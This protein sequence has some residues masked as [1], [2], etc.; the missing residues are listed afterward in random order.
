MTTLHSRTLSKVYYGL[1]K[2]RGANS[3]VWYTG[4][5]N[6]GSIVWKERGLRSTRS[7]LASPNARSG[8]TITV[9][10]HLSLPTFPHHGCEADRPPP[11]GIRHAAPRNA[12]ELCSRLKPVL[13]ATLPPSP[14]PL[15][16]RF[17]P[18]AD[19]GEPRIQTEQTH[20]PWTGFAT[21]KGR[22][23][24][25]LFSRARR[26]KS[27]DNGSKIGQRNRARIYFNSSFLWILTGVQ[28]NRKY[29]TD[30]QI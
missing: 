29:W 2:I 16:K 4:S 19:T 3:R 17:P 7:D 26:C 15:Q 23:S 9:N 6:R 14:A 1:D 18:A 21:K 13:D 8:L 30:G 12:T 22:T 27:L 28:V 11:P 24:A 10:H 20:T 25:L 5:T